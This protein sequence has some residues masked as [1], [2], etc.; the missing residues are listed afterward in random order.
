MQSPDLLIQ[1]IDKGYSG[2]Y[3]PPSATDLSL[4]DVKKIR[5]LHDE[6]ETYTAIAKQYSCSMKQFVV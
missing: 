5:I 4:A 1:R 2:G 3:K 6:G